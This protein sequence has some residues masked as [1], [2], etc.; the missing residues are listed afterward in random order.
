ML[1]VVQAYISIVAPEHATLLKK[2]ACIV[3][4]WACLWASS[5]SKEFPNTNQLSSGIPGSVHDGE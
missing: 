3:I 2:L 1:E 4:Y 5:I